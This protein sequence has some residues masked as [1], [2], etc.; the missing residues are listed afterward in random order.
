M[1]RM[2][3]AAIVLAFAV[4]PGFAQLHEQARGHEHVRAEINAAAGIPQAALD[5]QMEGTA[6]GLSV[7][8]GG[9]VPGL[10]LVL[11]SEVG[12]LN[13]GTDS[14][15]RLH[16]GSFD[17]GIDEDLALPLEAVAT[18]VSN[19]IYLGHFVVRLQPLDGIFQ[20]YVDALAGMK[21]FASRLS[22]DGDVVVFREG[23][24]QA[25]HVTD[26]AFSYGVGAGFE[27]R[28]YRYTPLFADRPANVALRGGVRYL[29]GTTAS[30]AAEGS[31]REV[32]DRILVDEVASRTDLLVPQLGLSV[33]Y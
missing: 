5:R 31:L 13:Y 8:F 12:F 29:F 11:G 18:R 2:I 23:L 20:P 9:P 16:R 33:S 26:F 10:P 15:L 22:V 24:S 32:G 19:N 30:Y 1:R 25:A 4:Q 14:Q 21:V 17:A 7:F 27:L 28:L 3:S 6:G